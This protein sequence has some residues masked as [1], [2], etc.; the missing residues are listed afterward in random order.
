MFLII[1]LK[2][3]MLL[4]KVECPLMF[5]L[6][7]FSPLN[8]NVTDWIL[9]SWNLYVH[10]TEWVL[11]YSFEYSHNQLKNVYVTDKLIKN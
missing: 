1:E 8:F 11:Q 5:F 7:N 10:F 4:F 9:L 2:L 6:S 3:L